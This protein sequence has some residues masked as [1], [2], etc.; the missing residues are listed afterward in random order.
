MHFLSVVW[1]YMT[2]VGEGG[3]VTRVVC[4]YNPCY[5]KNATSRT[6]YK[7]HQ[8]YFINKNHDDMCPR[9]R[10]K[11][12]LIVLL[13]KWRE[14]GDHIIVCMD[15][16]EDIYR[17]SIGIGKTLTDAEGLNMREW[18]VTLRGSS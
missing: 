13:K 12:D 6:S 9:T 15:A 2:F 14:Q 7:Q 5:N 18:W 8:Q 1:V 4:C 3:L 17:K 16:N 10:F 11:Q